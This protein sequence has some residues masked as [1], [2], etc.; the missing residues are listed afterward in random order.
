M[1]V[2]FAKGASLYNKHWQL[3]KDNPYKTIEYTLG[4]A[5]QRKFKK[6]IIKRKWL[7][8]EFKAKYPNAKLVFN[9]TDKVLSVTLLLKYD[10]L[11]VLK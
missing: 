8:S 10:L 9:S 4:K 5:Q 2:S 7:D 1:K 6:A 11:Y 3:I